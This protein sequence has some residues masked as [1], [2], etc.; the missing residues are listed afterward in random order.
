MG[1]FHRLFNPIDTKYSPETK[2]IYN[3]G[4]VA[5]SKGNVKQAIDYFERVEYEHPSAAYNLGL[6]YLDGADVLVPD[7]EKARQYFQQADEMGHEKAKIS[8]EIIGLNEKVFYSLIPNPNNEV[9]QERFIKSA[10]QFFEG[11]QCGNLAYI[12]AH[13]FILWNEK[14]TSYSHPKVLLNKE[15]FKELVNEF[16]TYEVYCIQNF[17]NKEVNQF[18]QISSLTNANGDWE[19]YYPL[20]MFFK[21][22]IE[23]ELSEYFNVNAIP[24]LL[25]INKQFHKK[26]M[27]IEDFG[28]LRLMVVNYVYEY[29]IHEFGKDFFDEENNGD[30]EDDDLPF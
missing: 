29:C 27:K 15:K 23:A 26:N 17:A 13:M 28:V 19:H 22:K 9:L 7:Y 4:V 10:I 6:I 5:L 11:S 16:I 1:F 30:E 2:E 18:Y 21:H 8:A 3:K 14:Y 20:N 12:L 24:I 25:N